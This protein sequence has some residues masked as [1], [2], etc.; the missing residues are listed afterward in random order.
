MAIIQC[1]GDTPLADSHAKEA[2]EALVTAYPNHSWWVDCRQD[3]LVIKHLEASGRRGNIGMAKRLSALSH[4]AKKRKHEIIMAAGEL[5]ER[6][7]LKRG[8]RG[9]EP[10]TSIELD[11]D[12]RR[13]WH[14][15]LHIKVT[16]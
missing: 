12:L 13:H 10:V 6:C 3:T 2:A 8:S 14:Q 11:A 5:L 1:Y 15:P 16:H 9:D 4:D 7:G